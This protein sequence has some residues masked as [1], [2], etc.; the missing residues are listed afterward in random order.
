M[1][2]IIVSITA[3][4]A[5]LERAEQLMSEG[6]V[7]PCRDMENVF[8]VESSS[9]NGGFYSVNGKCDCPDAQQREEITKGWCKHRLAVELYKEAES[10]WEE[11]RPQLVG[12]NTN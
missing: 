1:T 8:Y 12:G 5:R 4:S 2:N 9:K 11:V 7:H 6:K 10:R 3:L